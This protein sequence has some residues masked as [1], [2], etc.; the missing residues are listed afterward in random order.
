MKTDKISISGESLSYFDSE[1]GETTLLFIHGAFINKEYW[2]DQ[3]SHFSDKYRVVAMDLAG[4]GRSS[5]NRHD[6]TAY[7]FGQDIAGLIKELALKN[8]IIIGHSA[9]SDIM[10]ETVAKY[11]SEIKG[12]IEID[13]MKNVGVSLPPEVIDHLGKSLETDFKRTCEQYARQALVTEATDPEIVSKLLKDYG[14]MDP[15]VGIPF[16]RN[17]FDYPERETKL[18]EGLKLKLH[19]I[20]VDYTPTNKENLEKYLGNSYKLHIIDGTCHYPMLENPDSLN[21]VIEEILYE[22]ESD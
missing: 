15:D 8:V 18:L 9:G 14:R 11:P 20:H 7:R 10:L 2:S 22:I 1:K 16:L 17:G 6:W 4:H 5:Q 19:L 13:H 21:S 12:L 3:L